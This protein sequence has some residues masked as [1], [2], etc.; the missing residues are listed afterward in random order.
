MPDTEGWV[1]RDVEGEPAAK[2][3]RPLEADSNEKKEA[4]K[5]D[6]DGDSEAKV[7]KVGR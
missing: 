5:E 1:C 4:G 3:Q 6:G 7:E 2:R